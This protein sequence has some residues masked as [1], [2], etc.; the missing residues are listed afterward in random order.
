MRNAGIYIVLE[1]LDG[2]GKTT[3]FKNLVHIFKDQNISFDTL[4][5]TQIFSMDSLAE[6]FYRSN[7]KFKRINFFRTLIFAYRSYKATKNVK[8]NS[9]LI[10]GDRSIIVSYVKHWRKYFNSPSLTVSLVNILEPFIKSPNFVFLFHAP[11]NI[12]WQRISQKAVIEIDET[13]DNLRLMKS[14]YD[15][16]RNSYSISRLNKTQWIDINSNKGIEEL[17]KEVYEIINTLINK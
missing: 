4:C 9:E 5:P 10:L 6:K 14:A 7:R 11:E 12:L 8:W 15:E 13:P 3:V 1:G 17:T 2:S 16:I